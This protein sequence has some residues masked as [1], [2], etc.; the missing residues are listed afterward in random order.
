MYCCKTPNLICMIYVFGV[1]DA[2]DWIQTKVMHRKE[3]TSTTERDNRHYYDD[4]PPPPT[5][6][7]Y[8]V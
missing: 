7:D 3:P 6:D 4:L 2:R 8:C 1:G 5:D